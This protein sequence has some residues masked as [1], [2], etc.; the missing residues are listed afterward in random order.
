MQ[1]TP[2]AST[3][4]ALLA[5]SFL[6]G[7]LLGRT[8]ASSAADVD[9]LAAGAALPT[10]IA[11]RNLLAYS[12]A[13]KATALHFGLHTALME[14]IGAVLDGWSQAS[15]S[16]KATAPAPPAAAPA[17]APPNGNK[18]QSAPVVL[19]AVAA[20]TAAPTKGQVRGSGA[21]GK[22]RKSD[23]AVKTEG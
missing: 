6:S 14:C 1:A 17:S 22:T 16:H 15:G 19:R 8:S 23:Q 7:P 11:L 21:P 5:S 10:V 9:A 13:A 18:P 3:L 12:P 4:C 2:F 20:N